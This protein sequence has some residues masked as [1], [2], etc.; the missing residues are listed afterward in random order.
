VALQRAGVPA[1][2]LQHEVRSAT[3][4]LIARV[5]FWWAARA[6]AGEF[7]GAVKYGRLLRPGQD[8]GDAVFAEKLREDAVRAEG[9]RVVRWTWRELDD[10]AA[11]VA[12]LRL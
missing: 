1:P 9:L 7:D 8:A 2:L 4:L 11:V 5:D 12:R 3:G 10:F 6:T